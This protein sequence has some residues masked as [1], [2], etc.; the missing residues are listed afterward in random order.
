MKTYPELDK[1]PIFEDNDIHMPFVQGIDPDEYDSVP[2]N[3]EVLRDDC[4]IKHIHVKG[5]LVEALAAIF[6]PGS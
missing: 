3:V 1:Y 2:G 5:S 6:P 4:R